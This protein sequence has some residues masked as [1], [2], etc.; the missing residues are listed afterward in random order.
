MSIA[1]WAI[2]LVRS[3]LRKHAKTPKMQPHT[4][5]STMFFHP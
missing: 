5:I 1:A 2:M 3:P 4:E